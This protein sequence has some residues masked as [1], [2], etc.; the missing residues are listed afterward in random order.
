MIEYSFTGPGSESG[1]LWSRSFM[2][3]LAPGALTQFSASLLAE[4]AA[5]TWYL[6]YDRL[7]FSPTPRTRLVRIIEGR[8]YTN[9]TVSAR[10]DAENAG[11][12]PPAFAVDGRER[13]LIAW[14]KPGFLGGLK[15]GRGAKKVDETLTALQNE[16]PEITAQAR[17]WYDKVLGLRWSQ[18]EVLQIMEEIERYG[19]AA[20]LPYFAARHNLE[21][22]WR[23]LLSL[24]DKQPPQETMALLA[25]TLGGNEGAIESDMAQRIRQ[26][27]RIAAAQPEVAGWLSAGAFDDWTNTVPAGDF[28]DAAQTFFSL[29]GHRALA[30]GDVCN[31]R[32]SEQPGIVFDA[33][34]AAAENPSTAIAVGAGSIDALLGAADGKARK[35]VARLVE[36]IRTLIDMQSRAIHAYAYIL[37]ATRRWAL[38]AGHEA[39]ADHRITEIDNVFFYELEEMKQMMTGEWNVSDRS[40]IHETASERQEHYAQWQQAVPAGFIWGERP[41]QATRRGV[42]AAA[43]HASGPVRTLTAAGQSGAQP[44]LAVVQPGSGAAMLLA[45]SGGYFSAQGSVYDPLAA[46]ARTLVLPAVVDL[47]DSFFEF[48]SSPHIAIDG[49]AG[50]VAHQ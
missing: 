43:G 45:S 8:P 37:A 39:M 22:A 11:I 40:A 5:R 46:C 32:W 50:K 35:E 42:P 12:E 29:Y 7:G 38:A 13:V 25:A 1:Q 44:I 15:L 30:E 3:P 4:I 21:G 36:Q 16:L 26:L 18:A 19:A 41:M 33:I 48:L 47:G 10:L 14:Q 17:K 28:A 34:R 49:V 9:L 27:G 6:Y 20:L 23:R 31:P 24:L 2:E